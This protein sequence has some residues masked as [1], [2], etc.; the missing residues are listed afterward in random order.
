MLHYALQVPSANHTGEVL[1]VHS[2]YDG[3][4]VGKVD[5]LDAQGAEQAM[6]N[7]EQLFAD[8]DG[9]LSAEKRIAVL[10][11]AAS[12]M[13]ERFDEL[14]D[15][16]VSE[17]G[18]PLNDSRV[19][20]VRAIDGMKSCV[21]C[22]RTDHGTEIPMNLNAA[23]SNRIAYTQKEPRGVVLAF[24]AFNHPLNLIVHQVGPAIASGCPVII[25]PA[26]DTPLSAF[27]MCEILL[28]AGLPE[29]W[30]Q[31][32]VLTDLDIAG[33]M[34]ADKRIAFFSFIGSG[35]VGWMLRS[36]LAPGTHCALEHGG[37]AP[38]IVAEDADLAD[39]LPLL[40]KGGFYHAGQVCVSVQR[41]FAHADII[42]QIANGL[43]EYAGQAIVGDPA[44]EN[45]EIGPLIRKQEIDRIHSWVEEAVAEGATLLCG[46]K[47][48]GESTYAPTVLL[49]PGT[50]SK[51]S[52][53]EIFGPVICVYSY[54][55]MNQAIEQANALPF[56][57]QASIFTANINTAMYASKRLAAATVMVND[58]TAFRV[59]WMP[60][61]GL[62]ESGYGIG[63]IPY[64]FEDMQIEKLT[65][66]RTF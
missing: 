32:I 35:R 37:V 21:E 10:E 6:Q 64:T 41:I 36:K 60:F 44:D 40:A 3:K 24:S 27:V 47:A 63:G 5:V 23:S 2:P 38:A 42:D 9:W 59:D 65:V 12:I 51:V 20:V 39:S 56:A 58:H 7:T 34:V 19:E 18:K 52:Q 1:D 4:L 57:F 30:C 46:G 13:Q 50:D 48:L 26:S 22:I 61:A 11:R 15:I 25:K 49:N 8:R 14:V 31:A 16:A 54:D 43:V 55:D 53:Q 66:I 28:E 17:G 33:D 29:G 62:R 45:T